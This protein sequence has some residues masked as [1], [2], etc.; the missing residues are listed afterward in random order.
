[1]EKEVH[2][3]GHTFTTSSKGIQDDIEKKIV[4]KGTLQT[5]FI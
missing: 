3:K 1:M 5:S 4:Y 2:I